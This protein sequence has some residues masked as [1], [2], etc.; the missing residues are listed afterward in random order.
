[1]DDYWEEAG[2]AEGNQVVRERLQLL[3]DHGAAHF[4]YGNA[5]GALLGPC[6]STFL[7][8]NRYVWCVIQYDRHIAL[9]RARVPCY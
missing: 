9:L 3:S 7:E 6:Y 8:Q 2:L 1:M 4:H 5:G